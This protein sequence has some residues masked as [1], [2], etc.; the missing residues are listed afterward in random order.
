MKF[1]CCNNILHTL[2]FQHVGLMACGFTYWGDYYGEI[3]SLQD[4]KEKRDEIVNLLKKGEIPEICKTC[5][6]LSE[7][8]WDESI[9]FS[10][11]EITNRPKCSI[12]NCIYCIATGAD[13]KVKQYRN[14]Y[15]PYDIKPVLINLRENNALLPNCKFAINGGEVAEYPKKELKWLIYL[16]IKQNSPISILSSGIKYSKEIEHALK[17]LDTQIQISVDAGKPKT[18][19]KIKRVKG[20]FNK[21]WNNLKNYIK[22]SEH[23]KRF[24]YKVIIKFIII[25]GIND[26]VE[27]IKAFISKCLSINCKCI[28]FSIEINYK[29]NHYDTTVSGHLLDSIRYIVDYKR[30]NP[31]IEFRFAPEAEEWFNNQIKKMNII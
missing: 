5:G 17:F 18:Y 26:N 16:A 25:P 8:E 22:A 11:V 3:F 13:D 6:I 24:P 9:G 31:D 27:E 1:K 14:S 21:V 20:C 12:C 28:V 30:N 19:E 23:D 7:T 15:K 29:K 2:N 10:C 4:Y